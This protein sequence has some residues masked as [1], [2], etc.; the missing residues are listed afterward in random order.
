MNEVMAYR[1]AVVVGNPYGFLSYIRIDR[2]PSLLIAATK[3]HQPS[4]MGIPSHITERFDHSP[5]V[6]PEECLKSPFIVAVWRLVLD[7]G[8]SKFFP[9]TRNI[10]PSHRPTFPFLPRPTY[11]APWLSCSRGMVVFSMYID[12]HDSYWKSP[13]RS[14]RNPVVHSSTQALKPA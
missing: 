6:D 13:Y 12:F 2:L 14:G 1:T 10:S 9:I 3:A 11:H 7:H 8:P 4:I 5:F